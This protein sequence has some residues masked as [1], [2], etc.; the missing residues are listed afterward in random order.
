MPKRTAVTLSDDVYAQ[1][2]EHAAEAG[3]S[4]QA[5]LVAAIEREA[6]RQLCERQAKWNAEHPEEVAKANEA[7]RRRHAARAERERDSGATSAA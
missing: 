1:I 5:W 3:T 4:A 7:S 2:K 6:F